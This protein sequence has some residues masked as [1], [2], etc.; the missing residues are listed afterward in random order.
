M[1][2]TRNLFV[3]HA[4]ISTCLSNTFNNGVKIIGTCATN[5][6]MLQRRKEFYQTAYIDFLVLIWMR[7]PF[8]AFSDYLYEAPIANYLIS[9]EDFHQA[10][11]RAISNSKKCQT[12]YSIRACAYNASLEYYK[13]MRERDAIW[14]ME[15][16]W[17][18][19]FIYEN[20]CL[21]II[22]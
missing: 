22:K 12:Q 21:Y 8:R 3:S 2:H 7:R 14:Q 18:L 16:F 15:L 17:I 5:A 20:N 19:V 4:L 13:V 11:H 10:V 9:L 1:S 6:S